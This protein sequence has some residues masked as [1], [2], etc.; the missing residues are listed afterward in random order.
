[1]K[2]KCLGFFNVSLKKLPTFVEKYALTPISASMG[3]Y[4]IRWT[5]FLN[6]SKNY[7]SLSENRGRGSF[8]KS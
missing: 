8:G 6:L 7:L 2:F 1:M 4:S 5:I 3:Y